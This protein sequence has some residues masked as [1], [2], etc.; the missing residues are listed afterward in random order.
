MTVVQ[1]T[2]WW[3]RY[4]QPIG[5]P[6]YQSANWEFVAASSLGVGVER[7]IANRVGDRARI[8]KF[9]VG[10]TGLAVDWLP[11]AA[12][13]YPQLLAHW[14]SAVATAGEA[15]APKVLFWI[16]GENDAL[17]LAHSLAYGANLATLIAQLRID[18]A[19][20]ELR[21]LIPR[22]NINDPDPPYSYTVNV[23]NGEDAVAAADPLVAVFDIDSYP[24]K[25]GEPHWSFESVVDIGFLAANY[26]L[27]NNWLQ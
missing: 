21:V 19:A 7:S 14:A 23:R 26:I 11:S 16:Q 25:P 27:N 9:A 12:T 4:E 22:L 15:L 2:Q 3:T 5:V 8:F 10:G 18:I 1:P 6:V 20:P 24:L 13:L 17:N